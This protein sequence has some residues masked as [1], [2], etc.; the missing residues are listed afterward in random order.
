M[1]A[2][3]SCF[4]ALALTVV[5]CT[6]PTTSSVTAAS[7]TP[8]ITTDAAT[9]APGAT[10]GVSWFRLPGNRDRARR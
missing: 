1:A 2:M 10:I 8:S 3:K 7:T 6:S 4:L 9:Y 5:G